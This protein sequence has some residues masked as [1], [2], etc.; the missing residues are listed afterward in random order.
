MVTSHVHHGISNHWQL[1]CVFSSFVMLTTKRTQFY[2]TGP[3]WGES[4]DSWWI[5]LTNLQVMAWSHHINY[6]ID[7]LMQERRNSI[8]ISPTKNLMILCQGTDSYLFIEL[9]YQQLWYWPNT[10]SALTLILLCTTFGKANIFY[11][12]ESQPVWFVSTVLFLY[13]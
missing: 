12:H 13:W 11:Q 6:H 5:Y 3:L 1:N 9:I 10:N 7:G 2:L 4:A 8:D